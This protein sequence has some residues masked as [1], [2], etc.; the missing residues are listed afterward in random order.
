M[1]NVSDVCAMGGLPIAVTDVIW[2]KDSSDAKE[3]WKGMKAASE[4]YGVPIVGGHTC[5]DSDKKHLSV[6][7]LGK[8]KNLI[9]SYDVQSGDQLIYAVDLNGAYYKEY[10]FWN[11]STSS[12]SESLKEKMK[13]PYELANESLCAAG[14]D[15]S[16]GG[17]LGTLQ[18]LVYTAKLGAEVD[19]DKLPMVDKDLL[20]W[21]LAFPS[22]GY[23]LAVKKEN[24]DKVIAKFQD[25][26]VTAATIGEFTDNPEIYIIQ[27]DQR[28]KF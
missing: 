9:T 5:Y 13:V 20:R 23:L 8:A 27:K 19:L 2:A 14:K 17:L 7:I 1:V 26:G 22:Y 3:L 21:L 11:A 6:S 4:A 12:C 10:P 15:V 28:V 24:T 16:M 18:M 25:V